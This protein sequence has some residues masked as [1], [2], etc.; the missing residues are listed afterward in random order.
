MEEPDLYDDILSGNLSPGRES[1][2]EALLELGL[3]RRVLRLPV[4]GCPLQAVRRAVEELLVRDA[5]LRAAVA[6][7]RLV[8]QRRSGKFDSWVDL[9]QGERRPLLDG[10]RLRALVQQ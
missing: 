5:G 9:E 7:G 10:E 8:F 4:S 1:C 3:H 6:G 2:V